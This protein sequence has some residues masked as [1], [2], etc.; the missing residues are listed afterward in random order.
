MIT[1]GGFVLN[2]YTIVRFSNP[3]D[4]VIL[5]HL[6]NGE[7]LITEEAGHK[8]GAVKEI[9]KGYEKKLSIALSKPQPL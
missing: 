5:I 9:K 1:I 3:K 6:S 8:A 7:A 2:P 4:K